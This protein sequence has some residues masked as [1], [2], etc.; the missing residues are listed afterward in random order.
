MG[1]WE[2]IYKYRKTYKHTC[3]R[4]ISCNYVVRANGTCKQIGL[5]G[6]MILLIEAILHH[7]R[8]IKPCKK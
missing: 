4:D 3:L 8:C 7:L 5:M 6:S 2:C 1:A